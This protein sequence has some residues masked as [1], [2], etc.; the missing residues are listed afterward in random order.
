M[1]WLFS[2]LIQFSVI[3]DEILSHECLDAVGIYQAL[4][5]DGWHLNAW[6]VSWDGITCE[7]IS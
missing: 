2:F 1:L 5:F 3:L 4:S 6:K 7:L